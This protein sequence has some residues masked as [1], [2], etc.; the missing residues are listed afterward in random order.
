MSRRP[1]RNHSPAFKAKVALEAIRGDKTIA[2]IAHKHDVHPN[3]VTDWRSQ[4]IE[5]AADVFGA[6][7]ALCEP[8]IDVKAL[9]AKIGQL[10]LENDFLEGALTKAGLLSARR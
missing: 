6:G 9:H 7:S 10:A 8:T 2:E 5:R 4:M 3:Q 1:R